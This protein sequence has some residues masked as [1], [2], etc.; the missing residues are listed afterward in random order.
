MSPTRVKTKL[1]ALKTL[2]SLFKKKAS[3]PKKVQM[4]LSGLTS[5]GGVSVPVSVNARAQ[6][7]SRTAEGV[8]AEVAVVVAVEDRSPAELAGTI[9]AF[10]HPVLAAVVKEDVALGQT[11]E[12]S[13]SVVE[14]VAVKHFPAEAEEK[15]STCDVEEVVQDRTQVE[16]AKNSI[17][18]PCVSVVD[19]SD[20]TPRLVHQTIPQ[21]NS[22]V[23]SLN[24]SIVPIAAVAVLPALPT[25]TRVN[26]LAND[27][28]PSIPELSIEPD[29]SEMFKNI[30]FLKKADVNA[31]VAKLQEENVVLRELNGVLNAKIDALNERVTIL[32]GLMT[33]PTTTTAAP[34]AAPSPPA[35]P[36]IVV[37]APTPVLASV[38]K[39]VPASGNPTTPA[40]PAGISLEAILAAA[41]KLKPPTRA[42]PEAPAD[43]AAALLNELGP[44]LPQ[45]IPSEQSR[46]ELAAALKFGLIVAAAAVPTTAT[47]TT[48]S[49][50][51]ATSP[52][53][54]IDP[55]RI[56]SNNGPAASSTLRSLA[57][58]GSR[59]R[60]S[61]SRSPQSDHSRSQTSLATT[62]SSVSVAN[63]SGPYLLGS[64]RSRELPKPA[65]E[66][67]TTTTTTKTLRKALAPIT[68]RLPSPKRILPSPRAHNLK[69]SEVAKRGLWG[70]S[71]Q[72]RRNDEP[73]L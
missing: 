24:E 68:N 29:F 72:R 60:L 56:D 69:P 62:R 58:I 4:A 70:G 53:T 50:L 25:V 46:K 49:I 30:E 40:R 43:P 39:Q 71:V 3:E 33:N 12:L 9:P 45:R 32:E 8:V 28:P 23:S 47:T 65:T 2:S 20:A 22:L 41:A 15:L 64:V 37:T 17:P 55:F 44:R 35:A 21:P 34:A 48:N 52:V 26:E 57:S 63:I 66:A 67:T 14:F 42:A 51:S 5:L 1:S 54:S 59:L 13:G 6:P 61:R 18:F 16:F 7:G 11:K 19:M 38:P 27:Q 36:Q 10:G 73:A 31:A